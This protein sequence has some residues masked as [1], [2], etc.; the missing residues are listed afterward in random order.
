MIHGLENVES[1]SLHDVMM[2]KIML[3]MLRDAYVMGLLL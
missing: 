2:L 1:L 3:L